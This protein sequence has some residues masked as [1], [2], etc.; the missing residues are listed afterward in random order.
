MMKFICSIEQS[1]R[2]Y[3]RVSEM[4]EPHTN[5]LNRMVTIYNR[6]EDIFFLRTHTTTMSTNKK[7]KMDPNAGKM[8]TL[9]DRCDV[10]CLFPTDEKEG[11]ITLL[12]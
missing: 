2:V 7:M 4:I 6:E 11:Y 12:R 3:I 5:S 8:F 1:S 9:S 10:R